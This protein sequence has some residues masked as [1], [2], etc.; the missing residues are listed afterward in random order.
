MMQSAV[1]AMSS[2]VRP[3]FSMQTS[4][5][6]KTKIPVVC[7]REHRHMT[8]GR[9]PKYITKWKDKVSK[10]VFNTDKEPIIA[11]NKDLTKPG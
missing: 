3:G 6:D 4:E 5:K 9:M 10:W 11:P 7:E 2:I 1:S 8:L